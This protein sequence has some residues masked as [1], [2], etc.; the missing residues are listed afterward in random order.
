MYTVFSLAIGI[1]LQLTQHHW[2][3][4]RKENTFFIQ[5][6]YSVAS[7]RLHNLTNYKTF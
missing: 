1:K 2:Q 4:E 5:R 6:N 7:F 3:F